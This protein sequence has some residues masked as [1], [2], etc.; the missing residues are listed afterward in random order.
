M[1][2]RC[3]YS[4]V[5]A[6]ARAVC[7]RRR[8]L[9]GDAD[10]PTK[11]PSARD[12]T[13]H[14]PICALSP[15]LP[16]LSVCLHPLTV[17][18]GEGGSYFRRAP[19]PSFVFL[20]ARVHTPPSLH[21]PPLKCVRVARQNLLMNLAVTAAHD[22]FHAPRVLPCP[23]R[24]SMFRLALR[25][26]RSRPCSTLGRPHLLWAPHRP[27]LTRSVPPT[28]PFLPSWYAAHHKTNTKTLLQLST[29]RFSPSLTL[30]GHQPLQSLHFPPHSCALLAVSSV[31]FVPSSHPFVTFMAQLSH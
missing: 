22:D 12:V 29:C 25:H 13:H 19:F 5:C 1:T 28:S 10:H 17:I 30:S 16:T 14:T 20:N 11:C 8:S 26:R 2:S 9:R 27:R 6:C 7:T 18:Q 15:P 21:H 4:C 24:T 23:Q 31:S 3:I